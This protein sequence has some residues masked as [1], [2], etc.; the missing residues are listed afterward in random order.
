MHSYLTKGHVNARKASPW[1]RFPQED[2]LNEGKISLGKRDDEEQAETDLLAK[3][4]G[5]HIDGPNEDGRNSSS[6]A[7]AALSA[8]K[9]P[10]V[11]YLLDFTLNKFCRWL[12]ILGV[13]ASLETEE[14]ERL[15]T[16]E[17][18]IVIF[19]RCRTEG[20]TLVTTSTKLMLR[21]DCPAGA[22]CIS[23]AFLSNLEVPMVHMFLTHGVVLEPS[24]FLCRCVVCNGKIVTVAEP[25]E[26][27]RILESYQCS[28]SLSDT[29]DV[30][31]CNTC[32]QGYWW[33]DRPTSSASRVKNQ[34]THLFELCLRA[35][36][37]IRGDL[38]MFDF[39]DVEE[40]RLKGWDESMKGSELLHH[41]LDVVEW[42]K[43]ERLACPFELQS[44]YGKR[45]KS[46][47]GERLP[48]T[49][50]TRGF[51][52]TLD[53]IFFDPSRMVQTEELYVPASYSE[54]NEDSIENG[55][56][57]PSDVWPSDHL[58]IGTRVVLF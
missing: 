51:V 14:E 6:S 49:N 26:K 55:H 45:N 31:E 25:D 15:R 5:L 23:P 28:G 41:K 35:G 42:L 48:F 4:S 50:V 21:H 40:Q 29:M 58:A 56:L 52:G 20:R 33:C 38:E 53:Y 13:D 57:L 11:R 10:S 34:A 18:R 19:Q 54:M 16:K 43:N 27:R 9:D 7:D 22:Y 36:V 8:T 2:K 17:G 30:Y 1:H 12:R 39:V 37:P 47:D 32:G 46:E 44:S 3:I 24:T